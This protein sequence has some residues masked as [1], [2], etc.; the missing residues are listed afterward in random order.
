[1]KTITLFAS[2]GLLLTACGPTIP[3]TTLSNLPDGPS[4]VIAASWDDAKEKFRENL[5]ETNSLAGLE[6]PVLRSALLAKSWGIHRQESSPEGY[7]RLD[8][9]DPKRPFER[10][11][12]HGSPRP[13]PSLITPP[14]M[15]KD[16]FVDGEL[17]TI[18]VAQGWKST[19]V[20]GKPVRWYQSYS[21]GGADGPVWE[22]EGFSL[23]DPNGKTGYYYL[24]IESIT[25]AAPARFRDVSW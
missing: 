23:T 6:V 24:E 19:S 14:K 5:T 20:L 25:D 16:T 18:Q 10:L 4:K 2:A 3:R 1:M 17:G 21:G 8:Y 13:F 22:T 7:Y 11:I 15:D 9:K 12:I